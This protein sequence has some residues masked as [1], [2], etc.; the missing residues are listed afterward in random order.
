MKIWI[1]SVFNGPVLYNTKSHHR[2]TI[3]C[4]AAAAIERVLEAIWT[5]QN[6]IWYHK[7]FRAH[8][9]I[10]FLTTNYLKAFLSSLWAKSSSACHKKSIMRNG[11]STTWSPSGVD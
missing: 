2:L 9:R 7:Y 10:P 4:L 5:I 1:F 8:D 11:R 6:E 3:A